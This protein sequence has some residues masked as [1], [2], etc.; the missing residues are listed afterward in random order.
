LSQDEAGNSD[1]VMVTLL[2]FNDWHVR[3]EPTKDRW[4]ALCTSWDVQQG[5]VSSCCR[6]FATSVLLKTH[7]M[8]GARTLMPAQLIAAA[9]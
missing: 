9:L 4:C 3:V 6:S 7:C 5:G 8:Q 1:D 2:H